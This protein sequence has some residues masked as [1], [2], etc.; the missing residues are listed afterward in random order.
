MGPQYYTV[1][2]GGLD[3]NMRRGNFEGRKGRPT[4][5][6]VVLCGHLC[7]NGS[8]DRDAVWVWA[9]NGARP[10]HELDGVQ[11]SHKKG[12]F[13]GKVAHCKVWGLS[14]V[15]CAEMAKPIDLPFKLWTRVGR[16]KHEFN[17]IR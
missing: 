13:W 5:N 10:N 4:V 14:V 16:R 8:T 3:A 2:D 1:L 17:H 12:Q 6:I 9:Q 15:S 7:K 11:M